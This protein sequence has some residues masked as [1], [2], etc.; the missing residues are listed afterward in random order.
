MT[1]TAATATRTAVLDVAQELVQTRGYNAFSFRDLADRVRIKSAS[2]HYH[3]PTKSELCR[4]LIVRQREEL[5]AVFAGIDAAG[6]PAA[7]R[8]ASYV[9]VFR[10]TLAAGNRMCLCGMLASDSATL[11]ADVVA[12]LRAAIVDH[13]TWLAR[14]LAEGRGAGALRFEG[15]ELVE[16]RSLV[17]AL[18]GA[19]LLARMFDDPRRFDDSARRLLK[20]LGA[21][22][23]V[24]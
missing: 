8:L 18:E 7:G 21:G 11:E 17:A 3:F 14:V 6:L 13:E 9:A 5:A 1:N 12:E 23:A 16:A 24:D 10:E 15:E 4:T 22:P 19:M 2:V 20:Q